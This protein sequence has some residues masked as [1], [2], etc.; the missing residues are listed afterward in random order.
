MMR[1]LILGL[2]ILG[3]TLPAPKALAAQDKPAVEAATPLKIQI[4][5][6]ETDGEKKIKSLPYTMVFANANGIGRNPEIAKLR[7][8]SRVPLYTG[9]DNGLQY[10]DIGTNLDCRAERLDDGRYTLRLSLERSWVQADVQIPMEQSTPAG[11]TPGQFKEPV[12]GQYKIDAVMVAHVGQ[13]VDT[14]MATDPVTGRTLK[15]DVTLLA[16]K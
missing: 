5:F 10:I 3:L 7:V 2:M 14:T 12:I 16:I 13:P 8:G 15:I 1:R 6:T 4:V 9:K 11:G